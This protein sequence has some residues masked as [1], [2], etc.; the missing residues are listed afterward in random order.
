MIRRAFIVGVSFSLDFPPENFQAVAKELNGL[1]LMKN[2]E[3]I[4][5]CL[6]YPIVLSYERSGALE[7][8]ERVYP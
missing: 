1:A 7:E 4:D 8:I 2:D 5:Q 3:H 6:R